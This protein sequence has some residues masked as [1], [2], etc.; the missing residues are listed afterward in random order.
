MR[1]RRSRS[2]R[3]SPGISIHAPLT[4]CDTNS[5]ACA[6]EWIYFNPRTP[7]GVRHLRAA[8]MELAKDFNPRTPHGVR[9]LFG[10]F[11]RAEIIFQ[12][13][14]PSRGAT[15]QATR[16][17]EITGI[18]THAPLTGCDA[19]VEVIP[20]VVLEFQPTHPSRGATDGVVRELNL[21][22]FQPTHPSRGATV[23]CIGGAMCAPFQPTHPS[24]GATYPGPRQK[25]GQK[26][27]QPTH[28]SRGATE[29][30]DQ[31]ADFDIISTHAPLTGC[32]SFARIG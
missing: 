26:V 30:L 27:F 17:T 9:P 5:G 11:I 14:H 8:L 13:T 15:A 3:W 10:P 12:S 16:P 18:S 29:T 19:T 22:G 28:P 6:G 31:I 25:P 1:H 20:G 23:H 7:H 32:D 2:W 21:N 4:G 24:R